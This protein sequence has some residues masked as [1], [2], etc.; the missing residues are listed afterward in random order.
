MSFK[1]ID[2]LVS[3]ADNPQKSMEVL[4]NNRGHIVGA[5]GKILDFIVNNETS[6]EYEWASPIS[7][8]SGNKLLYRFALPL[9][10]MLRQSEDMGTETIELTGTVI[11]ADNKNRSW[12]IVNEDDQK[13]YSGTIKPGSMITLEGIVIF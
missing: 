12:M 3:A 7:R 4:R 11:K 5:Y 8:P 1:K 9:L 13:E 6:I 10:E 2:E